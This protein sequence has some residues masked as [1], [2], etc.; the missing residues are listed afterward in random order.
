M[1]EVKANTESLFLDDFVVNCDQ[2]ANSVLDFMKNVSDN[3]HKDHMLFALSNVK[4][5]LEKGVSNKDSLKSVEEDAQSEKT[6]AN[7][8]D[9]LKSVEEDAQ[10]E[11]TEANNKDPLKSVEENAQFEK[12]EANNKDPSK[13]VEENAQFEKTE[14]NNKDPSKSAEEN[15]QFEKKG[16]DK[17][18]EDICKESGLL[19]NP[20]L[21]KTEENLKNVEEPSY[22]SWFYTKS[23]ELGKCTLDATLNMGKN[24]IGPATDIITKSSIKAIIMYSPL[25]T[26]LGLALS[27]LPFVYKDI[28]NVFKPKDSFSRAAS[29]TLGK[30]SED[31]TSLSSIWGNKED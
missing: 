28:R 17:Y 10:S 16:D 6:E 9:P 20:Q 13:S 12:T 24:L 26:V 19:E 22:F 18:F 8:K 4:D 29:L 1:T 7:N 31:L 11:K 27:K 25:G 23:Y 14:A 21:E 30:I 5:S 3:D 15:A 2:C